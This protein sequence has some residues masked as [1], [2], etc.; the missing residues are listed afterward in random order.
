M[1]IRWF[2]VLLLALI[3]IYFIYYFVIQI[4]NEQSISYEQFIDDIS[5]AKK[6]FILMDLRNSSNLRSTIMQCS[7]GL[8]GS[9]DLA[10]KNVSAFAIEDNICISEKGNM[11]IGECEKIFS[12][13]VLFHIKESNSTQFYRNKIII[14]IRNK[15]AS[16][17]V[18]K[19]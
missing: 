8:A 4:H 9:I 5:S 13:G 11:T 7:V 12:S 6:V 18:S 2:V 3:S 17:S 10:Q 16:C 1:D 14:G 19:K 15:N